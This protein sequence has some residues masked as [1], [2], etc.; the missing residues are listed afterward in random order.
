MSLY[1]T[2]GGGKSTEPTLI[3]ARGN[4]DTSSKSVKVTFDKDYD[5]VWCC[6]WL[7]GGA[8]ITYT[9]SGTVTNYGTSV[10]PNVATTNSN[11]DGPFMIS[12]VK[13]GETIVISSTGCYLILGF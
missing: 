8:T 13:A 6:G 4:L 10:S 11:A 12:G 7:N 2:G 5:T 9:G 1:R 3:Y